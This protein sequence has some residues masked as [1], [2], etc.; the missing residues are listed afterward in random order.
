MGLI[1]AGVLFQDLKSLIHGAWQLL[2]FAV[3]HGP[4]RASVGSR[5]HPSIMMEWNVVWQR[6]CEMTRVAGGSPLLRGVPGIPVHTQG[7]NS[8]GWIF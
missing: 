8:H 4:M 1:E 2:T 3:A 6:L 7:E 5:A